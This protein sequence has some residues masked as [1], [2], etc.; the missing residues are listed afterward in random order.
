MSDIL[1]TI[2]M[3]L[4]EGITEFLPISSTGHLILTGTL[5]HFEGEKANTFE[6][7]IQLGAIL[8]V[9]ALYFNRFIALIPEKG[10]LTFDTQG[11]A[12]LR[13]LLLLGITTL[14]ALGLGYL[15][16]KAIKLYLFGPATVAWAL[17]I[18]G[19]CILLAE[20]FKPEAKT[21]TLDQLTYRQALAVG[22]FQCFALWPG[23]SRAAATII[24]GL[25]SGVDRKVAAEYSFLAAVPIMIVATTY[26]LYKGWRLLTLSDLA[27]LAVGFVVSFVSAAIAVKFF[28]GML[29]RWSLR[30]FAYYRIVLSVIIYFALIRI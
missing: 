18:G 28:V 1:I 6:I 16:H 2:I 25:L 27:Y 22:I 19:I 3:G 17:G 4:V 20:H 10:R 23:V 15:T 9:V 7:F 5:L 12:G 26:D 14:P 29:Q 8:A 21:N 24:G 11:F 13:G 30:P